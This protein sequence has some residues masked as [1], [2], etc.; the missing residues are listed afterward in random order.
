MR[1]IPGSLSEIKIKIREINSIVSTQSQFAK[2]A[3]VG[4]KSTRVSKNSLGISTNVFI[5]FMRWRDL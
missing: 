4:E 1:Q 2:Y 3:T 5:A